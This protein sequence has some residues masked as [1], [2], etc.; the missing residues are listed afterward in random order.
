MDVD[1]EQRTASY[2]EQIHLYDGRLSKLE[3]VVESLASGIGRLSED[4]SDLAV[5]S[6]GRAQTN[7]GTIFAGVTLTVALLAGYVGLPLAN[8]DNRMDTEHEHLRL[9]VETGFYDINKRH[10]EHL[11]SNN[12]RFNEFY[13]WKDDVQVKTLPRM[14]L[15]TSRLDNLSNVINRL[16]T[17][18]DH[19]S[20]DLID[21]PR[22][23]SSQ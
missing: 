17:R 22:S 5:Y 1:E 16:E 11:K 13:Q 2:V 21:H 4:V 23:E 10:E 14:A 18:I 9:W 19:I 7:W 15:N 6:R 8:L 12:T 3:A 20:T